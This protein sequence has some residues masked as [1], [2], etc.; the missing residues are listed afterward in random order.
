MCRLQS[1]QIWQLMERISKNDLHEIRSLRNW[2]S[3]RFESSLNCETLQHNWNWLE[4][5]LYCVGALQWTRFVSFYAREIINFW[6][7]IKTYNLLDSIR[8]EVSRWTE[9]K[10]YPFRLKTS[11]Y[12]LSWRRGE[13]HWLWTL[14]ISRWK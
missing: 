10:D 3:S 6:K 4:F 14:Q 12:S 2:N 9:V 8:L 13:D 11:K 1:S 7:R 5:V